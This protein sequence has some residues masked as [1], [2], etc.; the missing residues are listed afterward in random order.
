MDSR[1]VVDG[2]VAGVVPFDGQEEADRADALA[3]V[4]SGAPLCRPAGPDK[5][6]CVYFVLLDDTRR[7]ILLVDHVKAGLWLP[8]GG[9]VDEGEDPRV[10]AMREAAE[11]LGID[12]VFHPAFG[13]DPLFL[14]VTRTVGAGSHVDVTFW[15]L[16]AAEKGMALAPDPREA[17]R[18]RWFDLDDP[19]EWA[20]R[21]FDPQLPRFREK[22]RRVT[23]VLGR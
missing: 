16:L 7:S 5:H 18:V 6:L 9:H 8:P 11:E 22:L 17:H 23:C 21:R 15:F 19:A 4:R 2:L 10:T 20:G 13:D 12:G 3:W 14:S 1:A